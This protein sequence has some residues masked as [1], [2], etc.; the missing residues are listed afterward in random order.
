V[1][2]W[3]TLAQPKKWLKLKQENYN[4]QP[5]NAANQREESLLVM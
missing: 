4:G 3:Q 2:W 5:S 1:L